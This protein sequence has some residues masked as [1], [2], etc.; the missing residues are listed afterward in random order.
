M[1]PAIGD[2]RAQDVRDGEA[3]AQ[4]LLWLGH[5]PMMVQ[6]MDHPVERGAVL[7]EVALCCNRA[8]RRRSSG[9]K[10]SVAPLRRGRATPADAAD[11][12][13]DAMSR[14]IERV[15]VD[16]CIGPATTAVAKLRRQSGVAR[17][18]FV[19]LAVE[20]PGIPDAEILDK[21]LDAGS[22]LLTGDRVLHNLALGRGFRSFVHTPE[23]GLTDRRLAG[24]PARDRL[25]PVSGQALQDSWLRQP[26]PAARAITGSLIGL[27]S[28]RQLKQFR[29]KRRRIRAH[30]GAADNIAASA[31]TIAHR[32][33]PRGLIGGY[34]LKVD[35]RH[36]VKTLDPASEGY[37]LDAA[38]GDTPLLAMCW[39]LIHLVHLQLER[40][41]L[42]IYHFDAAA[43]AR[44]NAVI[45][46][47][48]C[49]ADA[50]ER[51]AACLLAA[52]CRPKAVACVKGR[53][54]DRAHEKLTQLAKF[55]TNELVP[56]DMRDVSALL[57][58]EVR[59]DG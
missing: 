57:A 44:C 13:R 37:F 1:A 47:P 11:E 45:A 14:R 27:W 29:T 50:I 17:A 42:T 12:D 23:T 30:F 21:L 41:P 34:Q 8:S 24:I 54:F 2:A 58:A 4:R 52:V 56:V 6:M 16:E 40:Y 26:D 20:H 19:F 38:A 43:L 18:E 51:M 49:A 10:R 28:E 32:R 3:T 33:A 9:M 7:L 55:A 31:L 36:G 39:A 5:D 15:I 25:L 46:D 59:S 53:F 22:V 35:A 48:D